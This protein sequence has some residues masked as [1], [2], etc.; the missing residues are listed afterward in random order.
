MITAIIETNGKVSSRKYDANVAGVLRCLRPELGAMRATT[1]VG[2]QIVWN[3]TRG[4][5]VSHVT[6]IGDV[7]LKFGYRSAS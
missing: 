1:F 7:K 5:D 3:F 6:L 4:S 2:H